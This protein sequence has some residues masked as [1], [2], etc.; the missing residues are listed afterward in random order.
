MDVEEIPF[1]LEL[2]CF[3]VM[4]LLR[5]RVDGTRIS[6]IS[7]FEDAVPSRVVGDPQKL[8]QVLVNLLANAV[9]FTEKGEI[10]LS[11]CLEKEEENTLRLAISV[12]DTGIGIAK[13]E[14]EE[15]FAAFR[16]SEGTWTRKYGGT[17][18]GLAICRR[19]VGMMNG[20]ITASNNPE[21]GSTF[22]FTLLV[23]RD[24][25]RQG[26]GEES[27]LSQSLGGRKIFLVNPLGV[28]AKVCA[29]YLRAAGARV[30]VFSRLGE[31]PCEGFP[32][33]IVLALNDGEEDGGEEAL[34]VT[35]FFPGIPVIG[36]CRPMQGSAAL[37]RSLGYAGYLTQPVSRSFL[38]EMAARLL[39]GQVQE[40]MLTRHRLREVQKKSLRVLVGEAG[41]EETIGA[42]VMASGYRR[43]QV[44]DPSA[45][46][47]AYVAEAGLFD[48]VIMYFSPESCHNAMVQIRNWE[49]LAQKP[50]TPVLVLC[51][52]QE[53]G[54]WT[55]T[56]NGYPQ[57]MEVDA[58]SRESLHGFMQSV[59][60]KSFLY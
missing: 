9:K 34:C 7:H 8:R 22:R 37:C 26:E 58:F 3:D 13:G 49:H 51:Q 52:K 53:R 14:E 31:I 44:A 16:Q 50:E 47:A 20:T 56:E 55:V 27:F 17:G 18:L 43:H 30:D 15:I 24:R 25:E 29:Q 1:D 2:L 23:R 40:G 59:M 60:G 21:G 6:L 42:L 48:G 33:L 36:L 45:L 5:S 57:I 32:D 41:P 4:E 10:V 19:L 11:V 46:V 38:V 28:E 39:E 35:K 54:L 12:R